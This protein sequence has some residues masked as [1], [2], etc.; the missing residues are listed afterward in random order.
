MI[1]HKVKLIAIMIGE[2]MI[3]ISFQT[4][5]TILTLYLD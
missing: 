3:Y 5:K 2:Y 1:I 4:T